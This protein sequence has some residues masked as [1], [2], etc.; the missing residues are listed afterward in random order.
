MTQESNVPEPYYRDESARLTLY[1]G[2]ALDLMPKLDLGPKVMT[3]TDPPYNVGMDYDGV[4]DDNRPLEEY[5]E[6]TY[7]WWEMAPRPLI[8]TPGFVNT[9]M[10]LTLIAWPDWMVPWVKMNQSAK[11]FGSL[12]WFNVWEPI[13]LYGKPPRN[14]RQDVIV[15]PIGQQSEVSGK[16]TTGHKV[17]RHP[18]PKYLP[19]WTKLIGNL[20]KDPYVVF[21]PF[22]GSGTTLL[23]CKRLGI[24]CVAI[25]KGQKY[26]DLIIERLQQEVLPLDAGVDATVNYRMVQQALALEALT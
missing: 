11:P 1:C 20:W 8:V 18:C 19:F 15:M 12:Q 4:V 16:T 6:W 23:A 21:D 5:V 2:D 26:C 7:K 24:P 13:L 9:Q 14:P 10:W 3:I 25:E 22:A 17:K